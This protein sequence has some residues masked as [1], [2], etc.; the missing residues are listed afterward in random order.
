MLWVKKGARKEWDFEILDL[1]FHYSGGCWT[2]RT[3]F[4]MSKIICKR[5]SSHTQHAPVANDKEE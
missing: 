1:F 2:L 5:V 4:L 3:S